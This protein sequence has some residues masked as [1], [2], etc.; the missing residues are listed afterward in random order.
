MTEGG[1][2]VT[3]DTERDRTGRVELQ[4]PEGPTIRVVTRQQELDES[5]AIAPAAERQVEPLA[6][7]ADE[8]VFELRDLSCYYG[9]FRAVREIIAQ[10]AAQQDHGPHRA[11]RLRQEHAAA[12]ASTG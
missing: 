10:R 7:T 2:R 12:L 5:E 9:A 3:A 1:D 8:V 4:R 11:V 6:F